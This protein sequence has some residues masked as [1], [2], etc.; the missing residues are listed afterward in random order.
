MQYVRFCVQ[1]YSLT[2][3]FKLESTNEEVC[4]RYVHVCK[5]VCLEIRWWGTNNKRERASKEVRVTRPPERC[6]ERIGVA[7]VT[8]SVHSL[9]PP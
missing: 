7:S 8:E 5:C 2:S 4:T 9:S 3:T 1:S 6:A